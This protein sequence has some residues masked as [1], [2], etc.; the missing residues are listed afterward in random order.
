M[1]FLDAKEV[2]GVCVTAV[3]HTFRRTNAGAAGL[4]GDVGIDTD[5]VGHGEEGSQT[6]ANLG[7]EVT[8]FAFFG[9]FTPSLVW[10]F[11]LLPLSVVDIHDQ[12][13][14]DENASQPGS[15]QPTS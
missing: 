8:A 3:R 5:N 2:F 15:E 7:K 10:L 6:G 1:H 9:L 13:P 14:Q 11:F 12:N 4:G